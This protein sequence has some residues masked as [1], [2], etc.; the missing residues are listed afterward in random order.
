MMPFPGALTDTANGSALFS[1]VAALLYLAMLSRPPSWRRTLAKT[2][3]V[4]L[5]ALLSVLLGG[6][7]LLTAALV[8]SALGD[9]CLAQDGER[10]FLSGLASFLAAHL[11][12]VGL[13]LSLATVQT[14]SEMIAMGLL[15]TVT[16]AVG[17]GLVRKAG[18]LA[19]PVALYVVAIAAM[20]VTAVPVGGLVLVGAIMFMASDTMLGVEKFLLSAAAP[21]RAVTAPAIWLLY[22]GGQLALALGFLTV[23]AL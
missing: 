7:V 19:L 2:A 4:G 6:P 10:F 22:Y 12:Y 18:Q 13:F 20:G 23:I 16:A 21:A 15:G 8:L 5:L 14:G 17:V 9:A 3:A 1:L 11:A